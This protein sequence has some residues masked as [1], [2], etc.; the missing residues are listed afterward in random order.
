M[1]IFF[2]VILGWRIWYILFYN[3]DS[4][5]TSPLDIVKVWEWGM[6]FHG[7]AIGVIVA[8]FLFSRK[9]KLSFL[10]ICDDIAAI[11]PVA[12]FFG[13]IWNYLNKE[14]LGFAYTG[15]FAVTNSTGSYFPSPLV[16]AI[17]EW[18]VLF[19]ILR[20]FYAHKKFHGQ[21]GALF[22]ILYG[23]FRTLVEIFIRTPDVQIGYYFWFVTQWSLLSIP[24]IF[25][26]IF[27]YMYLNKNKEN[28]SK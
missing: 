20:Y 5:L 28:V 15:P 11:V 9:I 4:F 21:I 6:S 23:V 3:F 14:L 25:I 26:W 1:Y 18:L 7:W 19:F 22:L 16:E 10:E 2:G 12:L 17:L 24:M 27:L 8:L 13:R